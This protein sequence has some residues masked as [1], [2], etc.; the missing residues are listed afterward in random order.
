MADERRDLYEVLGVARNASDNELKKAYRVLAKK[1]HP[2]ANPGDKEAEE[3]FKECSEAYAILSDPE[4]RKLYDTR[5]FA[6]FE[7]NAGDG[8]GGFDFADMGDIF[9]DIFGD[10]FGG[11]S[12]QRDYDDYDYNQPPL[13]SRRRNLTDYIDDSY[14][15]DGGQPMYRDRGGFDNYSDGYSDGYGDNYGYGGRRGGY[16][17]YQQPPRRG[18]S[19][20][21]SDY[22]DYDDFGGGFR[23]NY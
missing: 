11:G 18:G 10:M 12:R 23:G 7:Q 9:G 15:E 17:D 22:D 4:K 5:G 3:R 2:D 8:F 16:D 21:Y 19:S 13:R 20:G 14:Y 1:Y 6:A